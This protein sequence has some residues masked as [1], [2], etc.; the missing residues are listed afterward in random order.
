MPHA[1]HAPTVEAPADR[2][3]N[4]DRLLMSQD[5][6]EHILAKEDAVILNS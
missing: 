6:I 2:M 5:Y 1:I 4:S 3:R